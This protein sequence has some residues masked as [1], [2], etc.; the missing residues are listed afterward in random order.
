MRNQYRVGQLSYP[1]ERALAFG[2]LTGVI[3][4]FAKGDVLPMHAHGLMDNH[5]SIVARGSFTIRGET[6]EAFE[7]KSGAVLDWKVGMA[8]EFEALEDNSRMI[9][10]VKG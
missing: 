5:I 6:F 10:I 7:A 4:T 2:K 9:N 1:E 8:H 3:M